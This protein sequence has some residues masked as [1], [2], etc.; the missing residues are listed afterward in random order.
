M[1]EVVKIVIDE[2]RVPRGGVLAAVIIIST[3]DRYAGTYIHAIFIKNQ[4][5]DEKRELVTK[6]RLR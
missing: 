4:R 5:S 1:V 3:Y 2:S 6:I